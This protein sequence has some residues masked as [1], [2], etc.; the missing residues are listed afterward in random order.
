MKKTILKSALVALVGVGL[1][2]GSASAIP[3]T[4]GVSLSGG[5][6]ALIGT[7]TTNFNLATGVDFIN[8][9]PVMDATG[10]FDGLDTMFESPTNYDT[11]TMVDKFIYATGPDPASEPLWTITDKTSKDEFKF[12]LTSFNITKLETKVI[13]ISGTGYFTGTNYDNTDAIWVYTGNSDGFSKAWSSSNAPV[14]EPATMLLFGTGLAGL[15]G[16]ARKK[17]K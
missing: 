9:A 13:E 7:T 12:Y 14:P 15:A 16:I 8:T 4:G 5:F 17:K 6:A 3:L 1:M 11:A 10:S 2:A